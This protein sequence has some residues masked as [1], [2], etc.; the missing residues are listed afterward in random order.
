MDT[1]GDQSRKPLDEDLDWQVAHG[2][3]SSDKCLSRQGADWQQ[4]I[5]G[6]KGTRKEGREEMEN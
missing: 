6:H 4:D 1:T 3:L 2:T 5:V